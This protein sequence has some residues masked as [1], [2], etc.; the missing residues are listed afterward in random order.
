M[1]VDTRTYRYLKTT[2][3]C[4]EEGC[5]EEAR[6][7]CVFCGKDVCHGHGNVGLSIH[8]NTVLVCPICR[9]RP[10]ND[11]VGLDLDEVW[12]IFMSRKLDVGETERLKRV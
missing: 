3:F 6:G 5:E 1:A 7:P 9:Y 11:L 10:I 8:S 2:I 12:G 4:D